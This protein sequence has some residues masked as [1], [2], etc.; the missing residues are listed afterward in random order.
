MKDMKIS[1][2]EKE[3]NM[4]AMEVDVNDSPQYPYGLRLHLDK[5]TFK[6]LGLKSV[7]NVG[8]IFMIEAKANVDSVHQSER[9]NGDD[10]ISIDLQI[11]EME[12]EGKKK[13]KSMASALYD[14]KEGGEAD[15]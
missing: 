7:P 11:T 5:E 15:L 8:E 1:K 3:D 13:E 6:K 9:A 2:K 12:L 14:M 10:Y 4:K